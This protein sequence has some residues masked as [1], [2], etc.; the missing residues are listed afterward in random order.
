MIPTLSRLSPRQAPPVELMLAEIRSAI[1]GANALG[2]FKKLLVCHHTRNC[3]W[4]RQQDDGRRPAP[5][6]GTND[7]M[8]LWLGAPETRNHLAD[9][10]VLERA[11]I[12]RKVLNNGQVRVT[13]GKTALA[14]AAATPDPDGSQAATS[15]APGSPQ[16]L[17][18]AAGWQEVLDHHADGLERELFTDWAL[19]S[20][21]IEEFGYSGLYGDWED[22]WHNEVRKIT[23]TDFLQAVF[24]WQG[25]SMANPADQGQEPDQDEEDPLQ[26][27]GG[28]VF[29]IAGALLV[30]TA[31]DWQAGFHQVILLLDAETPEDEMNPLRKGLRK[32]YHDL[33]EDQ[34]A[35][36]AEDAEEAAHREVTY[37]VPQSSGGNLRTASLIPWVDWLHPVS[38]TGK[39]ECDWMAVPEWVTEATLLSLDRGY[40]RAWAKRVQSY[41]NKTMP[42]LMALH[43]EQLYAWVLNGA[44]I[45]LH[46]DQNY[47]NDKTPVYLIF[48]VWRRAV[49]GAGHSSIFRTV[50][51]PM[52]HDAYGRHDCTGLRSLPVIVETAE[53]V[54]MAMLSRGVGEIV[55]ADQNQ[56]IDL[57][58]AEG[59]RAQLG[60]NPPLKRGTETHV[61]VR[62]GMQMFV[63]GAGA[64]ENT[65]FLQTPP[66]D[67]GA[68]QLIEIATERVNARFWRGAA[69]AAD[70]DMK[71]T[72]QEILAVSSMLTLSAFWRLIFEI[73]RV[74]TTPE[75]LAA[76]AGVPLPQDRAPRLH[77]AFNVAGLSAAASKDWMDTVTELLNFDPGVIDRTALVKDILW[78]KN[79]AMA[80]LILMSDDTASAQIRLDQQSRIVKLMNGWKPTQAD[81]PQRQTNPQ[82][83][84]GEVQSYAQDPW[85]QQRMNAP[86]NGDALAMMKQEMQYL[87][88][89]IQQYQSNPMIGKSVVQAKTM[90]GPG[91]QQA[92]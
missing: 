6:Q 7:N 39:G 27:N 2:V 35:G 18:E 8:Y 42:E 19:F 9:T 70:P 5:R 14:G 77:V 37:F 53:P 90:A 72:M 59:A 62:P 86:Q 26:G 60:S 63:R 1:N 92:A 56:A 73:I 51:H 85:N 83:R 13:P 47:V 88:D 50:L 49:D 61:P 32:A 11:A 54:K 40:D 17:M 46:L 22:Q 68:L 41:P 23:L 69:G 4:A 36:N 3:W 82:L 52:I 45:G 48:H 38:M 74:N 91:E 43:L 84:I 21:C 55:I 58:D 20:T 29:K 24:T 80:K 67:Q 44:G 78:M 65:E 71:A 64:R 66:V 81:Y 30:A 76:L 57:A 15:S 79:P 31:P 34:E 89:Q 16:S 25:Q 75:E 10:I 87:T 12:R 28:E 33:Q